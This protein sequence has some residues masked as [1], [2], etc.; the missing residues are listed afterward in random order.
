MLS[1][2]V[3]ALRLTTW[4]CSLRGGNAEIDAPRTLSSGTCQNTLYYGCRREGLALEAARA[5]GFKDRTRRPRE[6]RGS[7]KGPQG[8][9]ACG[10]TSLG[11]TEKRKPP[12]RSVAR[13]EWARVPRDHGA[14]RSTGAERSGR[15]CC[16]EARRPPGAPLSF[17]RRSERGQQVRVGG[18]R[19]GVSPSL[20]PDQA[21]SPFARNRL[22]RQYCAARC[23]PVGADGRRFQRRDAGRVRPDSAQGAG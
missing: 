21:P 11:V 19:L 8:L 10:G 13:G 22:R 14:P 23:P 4:P 9:Q 7:R 16:C 2:L 12:P 17:A 15:T 6:E 3:S 18:R 20:A 1:W 5:S